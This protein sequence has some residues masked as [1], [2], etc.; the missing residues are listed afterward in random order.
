MD[1]RKQSLLLDLDYTA[2]EGSDIIY[3]N[4]M[5]ME[6]I[7]DDEPYEELIRRLEFRH[8]K[9]KEDEDRW[10]SA[11]PIPV[12]YLENT[13]ISSLFGFLDIYTLTCGSEPILGESALDEPAGASTGTIEGEDAKGKNVEYD[14]ETEQQ[15]YAA[16][17]VKAIPTPVIYRM[18]VSGKRV[19]FEL[20]EGG[21]PILYD[22]ITHNIENGYKDPYDALGRWKLEERMKG[23][24]PDAYA[25]LRADFGT[26]MHYMFG[27]YLTG[28]E[29]KQ[30]PS[31]Y[32]K[33]IKD[34]KLRISNKNMETILE[35]N[36]EEMMEDVLSFAIFCKDRNVKPVLIEKVLRSKKLRIA[37]SIDAVVEMDSE[38]E[39][40][41]VE[42]E[43]GEFYKT[44]D[45]KGEPKM[46]KTTVTRV[47]RIFAILDF[48]SNRKGNFYDDYAFQL[49]FYR[50]VIKENY[51]NALEIEELYNFAPGD[52]LSKT[53]YKLKRQTDNPILDMAT[54][55]YLQGKKKFLKSSH[56]IVSRT[57]KVK[58]GTDMDVD[59]MIRK[60]ELRDYIYRVMNENRQYG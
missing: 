22:G 32:R 17:W 45:R 55:V 40:Y 3:V 19:Y 2:M 39:K 33:T 16:E 58:L 54:L 24:D 36:I 38:P 26:I 31:W 34:A 20:D 49:E 23:H 15:Y 29:I 28:V 51:G 47:R 43:T 46:K 6:I 56:T 42:V 50:R 52:P 11:L 8:G 25:S 48:K 14:L 30:I 41:E 27:L 18:T 10:R 1:K 37:S 57:G 4:G 21:Y 13:G 44:G 7:S 53:R 35:E 60:E 59:S 5:F 12:S 9:I